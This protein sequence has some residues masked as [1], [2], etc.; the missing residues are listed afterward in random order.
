MRKLVLVSALAAIGTGQAIAASPLATIRIADESGTTWVEKLGTATIGGNQ[1]S[2]QAGLLQF[3]AG[4]GNFSM[5]QGKSGDSISA[6]G[7]DA[8]IWNSTGSYWSWHS[9]ETLDGD[10]MAGME[11]HGISG[12]GDPELSYS[13]TALN[14]KGRKQTYTIIADE[15]T[16]APPL[17]GANTVFAS[18]S[19][20][21]A[22]TGG[23]LQITQNQSFKLSTDGGSSSV[24]A[25][26]DLAS[27]YSTSSNG[28]YGVSSAVKAGPQNAWNYMQLST[29][30]TLSGG[31]GSATVEGYASLAPVPEPQTYAMLLAGLG[32]LGV[33]ARRRLSR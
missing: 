27:T 22:A 16:I 13:L 32:M 1:S 4:T 31:T 9:A 7:I 19:G 12:K 25:G 21:L 5:L 15:T 6:D 24:G 26:V 18:I 10:Y 11:L 30:F 3:D 28:S 23:T 20:S 33:I 8:W 29:V 14:K 2:A 17:S